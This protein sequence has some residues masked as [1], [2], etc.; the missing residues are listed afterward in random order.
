MPEFISHQSKLALYSLK[1]QYGGSIDIYK[2]VSSGTDLETGIQTEVP[3]V[4]TIEEAII[5]PSKVTREVR[6][7]ISAISANKQFVYGGQYDEAQRVVVID[8]NDAP[9]LELDKDDWVV[10]R[11]RRWQVDNFYS[12]E[13]DAAYIVEIKQVL[14][15]PAHQIRSSKTEQFVS[16][17]NN[18][19]ATY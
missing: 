13:F 12:N 3:E 18:A 5:L 17:G 2:A 15:S 19:Q 1:R 16:F 7:T 10:Y 11:N 9:D 6:Q 4:T 8:R 14:D